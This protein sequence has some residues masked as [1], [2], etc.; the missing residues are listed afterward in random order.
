MGNYNE[1]IVRTQNNMAQ[2]P[3]S[4]HHSGLLHTETKSNNNTTPPPKNNNKQ[5]KQIQNNPLT[6]T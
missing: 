4:I 1:Y 5:M 3:I 2:S 6:P